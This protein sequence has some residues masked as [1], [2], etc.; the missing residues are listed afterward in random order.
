VTFNS[1]LKSA[2]TEVVDNLMARC[3]PAGN[4]LPLK[5][6]KEGDQVKLSSGPL[7]SFVATIEKYENDQR[8]W[9]LMDLM[10]RKTKIAAHTKNLDLSH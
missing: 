10:G 5:K 1:I 6:L 7:A 9:V 2:P 4:L 3:D 8:I